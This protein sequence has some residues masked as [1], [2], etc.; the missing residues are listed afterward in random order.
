MH[1]PLLIATIVITAGATYLEIDET[2]DCLEETVIMIKNLDE[3]PIWE[4][5]IEIGQADSVVVMEKGEF[6]HSEY[7]PPYLKVK[8]EEN[9]ILPGTIR[10]LSIYKNYVSK[11]RYEREIDSWHLRYCPENDPAV[12][13][14]T[15]PKGAELLPNSNRPEKIFVR[16]GRM[17][18]EFRR[19]STWKNIDIYYKINPELMAEESRG[20]WMKIIPIA[21]ALL[22]LSLIISI[23]SKRKAKELAVKLMRGDERKIV[24]ILM[25]S[26]GELT[27]TEICK[28]TGFSK[29]KVSRLLDELEKRGVVERREIGRLKFVRLRGDLS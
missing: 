5:E 9:P 17:V 25:N 27:Q 20:Y 24:E 28:E 3:S 19:N 12:L 29:A 11:A 26:G 6:V 14:I 1:V 10:E 4:I 15:L 8:F 7:D 2:G 21:S 23:R 13:L 22:V 18:L 16:N